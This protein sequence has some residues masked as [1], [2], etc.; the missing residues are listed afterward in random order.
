[1]AFGQ[2]EYFGVPD[3]SRFEIFDSGSDEFYKFNDAEDL[4]STDDDDDEFDDELEDDEDD[5]EDD[6]DEEY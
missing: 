4:D 3:H 1:M 6:I 5:D 2:E